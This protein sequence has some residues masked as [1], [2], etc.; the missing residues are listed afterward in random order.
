MA[1]NGR[2]AARGSGIYRLAGSAPFGIIAG[3]CAIVVF[4]R[5]WGLSSRISF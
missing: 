4:L 2:K 1:D 3:A 5:R